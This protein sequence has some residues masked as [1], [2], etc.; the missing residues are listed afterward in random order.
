MLDL[1]SDPWRDY[2]IW[3]AYFSTG[4]FNHHLIEHGIVSIGTFG[5]PSC[6][7]HILSEPWT[8]SC[9]QCPHD[10]SP[11]RG[12]SPFN[13]SCMNTG[14]GLSTAIIMQLSTLMLFLA[15]WCNLS[16]SLRSLLS[17]FF[18]GGGSLGSHTFERHLTNRMANLHQLPCSKVLS[19]FHHAS[20]QM[21][22]SKTVETKT[23][24]VDPIPVFR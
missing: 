20:G 2:P 6:P 24:D 14:L 15:T 16:H 3:Q 17:F 1:N 22:P 21:L 13:L 9:S 4:W 10:S 7:F 19:F 5:A 8:N 23:W 18:W 11:Q 12:E